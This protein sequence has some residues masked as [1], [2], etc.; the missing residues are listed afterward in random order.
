L[1]RLRPLGHLPLLA[2]CIPGKKIEFR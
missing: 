1:T 2:C